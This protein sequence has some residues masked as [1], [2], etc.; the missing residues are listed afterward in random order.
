MTHPSPP[1]RAFHLAFEVSDLAQTD[2]FYGGVLGQRIVA[3]SPDWLIIDFFGHKLTAYR[4]T[5][6]T[7]GAVHADDLAKRHFGA[8]LE[9][10]AL[11]EV[12]AALQTAGAAI[13]QPANLQ[14]AGTRRAQ[15][16]LF[17]KDP[18]GNGLEFN[19]FPGGSWQ[20]QIG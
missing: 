13:M 1:S 15:W 12:E 19:A 7:P 11:L 20:D 3:R 16:V 14:N 8:V 5:D 6:A 4:T 18:S 17:A 10:D 9:P 2:A